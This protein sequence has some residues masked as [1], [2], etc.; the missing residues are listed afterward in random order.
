M[1]INSY[2]VAM[3]SSRKNNSVFNRETEQT[4]KNSGSGV[5]IKS[6]SRDVL[7]ISEEAQEYLARNRNKS[8]SYDTDRANENVYDTLIDDTENADDDKNKKGIL[9][10]E[11]TKSSVNATNSAQE[12]VF[13]KIDD[14]YTMRLKALLQLLQS[15]T[16]NKKGM[17]IDF[18]K[19]IFDK[20]E[21]LS[22]TLRGIKREKGIEQ[23]NLSENNSYLKNSFEINRNNVWKIQTKESV[24]V[25][26]EEVTEFSSAG[27]VK[28]ADGREISFNVNVE[29]SRSF[30]QYME[31][32]TSEEV[33][34]RDP[35]V[36]NLDSAPANISDQTF[37]FD[38][39]ADGKEDEISMLGKGSGFLALDKNNDGVINDGSELF[40][41]LTGNG[42][43]ELA[44]YDD[45]GNGW[46]DEADE[47][48]NK[49]KVWTKDENGKDVLL[50]LK[51]ADLG[52]IY[53][54]SVS[55][56]FSV[57]NVETNQQNAQVRST[58]VYLKESGGS[59]S[60]QQID[61]AVKN[62][63]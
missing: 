34:L 26:E 24:F 4:R 45:D 55:T 10:P 25:K 8:D 61:F 11:E 63:K 2:N 21:S 62:K 33:V 27:I 48:F 37:F 35:L 29:M 1:I 20:M 58:G 41:A 50:S 19:S 49:L 17:K 57:N 5:T 22:D 13:A 59:G 15:I 40:G 42:F 36:I 9:L 18:Q 47:I 3:N 44:K 6:Y 12:S 14:Y 23:N 54:N 30:E 39:D 28:T 53:L 51:E 46:I 52:A 7:T 43:K 38:I 56:E 60:I 16:K 31:H 32:Y